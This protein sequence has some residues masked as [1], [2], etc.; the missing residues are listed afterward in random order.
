MMGQI[1]IKTKFGWICA[2]EENNRIISV[3]FGK[4]QNRSVSKNLKK[5]KA[6]LNNFLKR[7]TKF[8][9]SSFLLR[10]TNT[11]KK[12]WAELRK[13]RFGHT[14]TYGEIAKKLNLSP[15]YIGKICGQNKIIL[16]IPCH[17]V[18]RSD[19]NLGGFSAT[20]GVKLKKKLLDFERN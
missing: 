15:R 17:R 1:S 16:V 4:H 11:Q 7:K 20:G 18:I 3:K 19:G 5:F 12:G 13:N 8:I 9:K 14:K 2:F 10:G 6:N